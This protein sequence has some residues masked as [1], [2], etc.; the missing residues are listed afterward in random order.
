MV[1]S[2]EG[3]GDSKNT[4]S[5]DSLQNITNQNSG[6]DFS[7]IS[8]DNNFVVDDKLSWNWVSDHSADIMRSVNIEESQ[9]KKEESIVLEKIQIKNSLGDEKVV[10]FWNSFENKKHRVRKVN[11]RKLLVISFVFFLIFGFLALV[12]RFYMQYMDVALEPIIKPPYDQIV[13]TVNKYEQIVNNY[14][15]INDYFTYQKMS[16]VDQ[17]WQKTLNKIVQS[18]RV[19]YLHKKMILQE[20][21]DL[22]TANIL[23][24]HQQL[25]SDKQ[26]ITKYG[27]IPEDVYTILNDNNQINSIRNSLLSLEVIKF[28]SAIKVFAYLDVFVQSFALAENSSVDLIRNKMLQLADRGEK[29][30]EV[31][32]SNCYLN[33][34]ELDYD[35]DLVGD[36]DNYYDIF[37]GD[38]VIDKDFFKKVMRYV[39]L[40][41]EQSEIPSFNVVF[42]KFDP[43][44]DYISFEIT[45]NT[46]KQDEKALVEQW[47]INPHIFVVTQLLNLL[48]QSRVILWESINIQD[49]E[50]QN[51]IV[52]I[53]E[54]TFD[55]SHS[56]LLFSLPIQKA[57]QREIFDFF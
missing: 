20:D 11:Y 32:L 47:I 28:S 9:K 39:D 57:E 31:Y 46:F 51:K 4:I 26:S 56:Q 50:V 3:Q 25:L 22:L 48:R 53:G 12:L 13:K 19:N 40:R 18:D 42:K 49:L 5:L 1:A 34:F 17:D 7:K 16:L 30:I 8:S 27:Y 15:N 41:L 24:S 54:S 23:K 43:S 29:D 45:V 35:C 6:L 10:S 36:F 52:Q 14:L 2:I 55:I 38:K 37:V 44:K 21:L 33:P